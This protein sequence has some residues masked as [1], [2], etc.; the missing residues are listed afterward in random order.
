[1]TD[2]REQFGPAA[3]AYLTSAAHANEA[4][5]ARAVDVAKPQGGVVVDVATGA[6]HTAF[7][8]APHVD[9]VVATD[10]TPEMLRVAIGAA[11]KRG[12]D[13]IN[14]C[15]AFAEALPFRTGAITGV[16]CRLGAHHFHDVEQFA[17]ET[18]R[19]LKPGGWLLLVDIVGV[20]DDDADDL[21]DKIEVMRDR[22]HVRDYRDSVW[23]KLLHRHHFKIEFKEIIPKPLNA[24]DW[25]RSK[26]FWT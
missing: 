19:V 17:A 7:A 13:N 3:E 21:L 14:A 5:L 4:A 12:L 11:R 10:I 18:A 15:F 24:Y 9:R 8:F 20:E 16:T 1:V 6:G 22:S 23:E 2:P 25:L 26:A